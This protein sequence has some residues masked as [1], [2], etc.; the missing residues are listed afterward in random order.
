MATGQT[1][2]FSFRQLDRLDRLQIQWT[3]NWILILDK[4]PTY[5][6]NPMSYKLINTNSIGV[7]NELWM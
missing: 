7:L 4:T 5:G 3:I 2:H 6:R 1:E